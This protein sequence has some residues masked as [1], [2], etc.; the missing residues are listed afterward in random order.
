[1]SLKTFLS[2]VCCLTLAMAGCVQ[3]A[4]FTQLKPAR[5][6][7]PI[8]RLVLL[9]VTGPESVR[10]A[11]QQELV[12]GLT[13][14]SA[15]E[16]AGEQDLLSAAPARLRFE[17]GSLNMPAI[18]EAARRIGAEG[19]LA[20]RLRIIETNGT[21]FGKITMRLGDPEVVAAIQYRLLDTRTGFVV[22]QDTVQS[23]SYKGELD[24]IASGRTSQ[25][26]IFERLA[27][28]SAA[29][30]AASLAPH[31]VPVEVALASQVWGTGAGTLRS[32]NHA[33]KNGDWG[34]AMKQW[35]DV[36]QA[37]QENDSAWYN[38]GLAHEAMGD[39]QRAH[40]AYQR[41]AAL[42]Q[43]ELYQGAIARLNVAA[44]ESRVATAQRS[45]PNS[46]HGALPARPPQQLIQS[47]YVAPTWR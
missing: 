3:R 12:T 31:E 9:D 45:R 41:A 36:I 38:L 13:R 14:S 43:N 11:A 19:V 34:E 15:Y 25:S 46:R 26:R 4:S 28:D 5:I 16:L 17:N 18:L 20:P 22:E 21:P 30:V 37:N 10:A 42:K 44:E 2:S 35:N 27:K 39:F 47:G 8:R 32:G 1:M 24:R 7:T 29:R 33:A 6:D 23:E 40:D